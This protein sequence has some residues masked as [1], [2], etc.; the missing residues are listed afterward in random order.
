VVRSAG[1]QRAQAERE[2]ADASDTVD[3]VDSEF[4]I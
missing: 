3:G 2:L 1:E 4:G